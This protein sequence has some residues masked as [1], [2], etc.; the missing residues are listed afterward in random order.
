[1]ESVRQKFGAAVEHFKFGAAVEHLKPSFTVE[2]V[3][4]EQLKVRTG[5]QTEERRRCFVIIPFGDPDLQVVYEDF[6]KP[7]LVDVCKPRCERGDDVFGSNVIMEDI[8]KSISG[9]DVVLADLTRKNANVFYEVGI[10]HALD[11]TG[12]SPRAIR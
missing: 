12:S 8:R 9:A 11:K 5:R 6:V 3:T 7:T 1:V 2:P 10:C 4:A